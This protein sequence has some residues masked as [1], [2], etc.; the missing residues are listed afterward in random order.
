MAEERAEKR[1]RIQE[2]TEIEKYRENG[3]DLKFFPLNIY[4][5]KSYRFLAMLW[6]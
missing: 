5:K 1:A 4:R 6:G 3:I 2:M